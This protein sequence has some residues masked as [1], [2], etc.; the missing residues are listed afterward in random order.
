MKR[1][2]AGALACALMSTAA[3][4]VHA[5]PETDTYSYTVIGEIKEAG[6]RVTALAIEFDGV[7]PLN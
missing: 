4:A 6:A 7:L 3:T 1:Y 2:L 5:A